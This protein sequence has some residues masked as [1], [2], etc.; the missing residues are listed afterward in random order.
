MEKRGKDKQR[1]MG[2]RGGRACAR[3]WTYISSWKREFARDL[4]V[5]EPIWTREGQAVAQPHG[6]TRARG[7]RASH[8]FG[9]TGAHVE[10][11]EGR[12]NGIPWTYASP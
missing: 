9:P 12:V 2:K 8:R 4:G 7:K 1:P 3:P 6:P 11:G 5:H 10:K